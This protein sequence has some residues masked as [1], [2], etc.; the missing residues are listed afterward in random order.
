MNTGKVFVLGLDCATPQLLFERYSSELPNFRSLM[1]RGAYGRLRSSDPPITVPAWTCMFSSRDPGEIGL[2]GFRN[3]ADRSYDS[4]LIATSRQVKVK[5]AW[6]YVSDAGLDVVVLGVPQTFPPSPVRGVMVAS[7]LTPSKDSNFTYPPL[8]KWELDRLA[9]DDGGY[10]IDID[11]FRTD[12]KEALREAIFTMT[13]RRFNVIRAWVDQRPWN[14]FCAVEMG[15]DRLHHGF[16]RFADPEHRL[17]QAGNPYASL[18]VVSDHGARRMEGGVCVNEWLIE[19]GLL[20]VKSYPD[21][22]TPLRPDNVVW[23]ET[24]VWG[25]GGYYGRVFLNVE[26]REPQG[27]I[28]QPEVAGFREELT[29]ELLAL[30][31][32]EGKPMGTVVHTPEGLYRSVRGVPPDLLV[33]FGDLA[34]RSVG[35]LGHR[36]IHTFSND[37]GPDDANH[38]HHGVFIA[39]DAKLAGRGELEGVTLYDVLPTI[40]DRLDLEISEKLVGRVL[41]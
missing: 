41:G 35:S 11:N 23:N 37:T 7:F 26:G 8:V 34:W 32:P 31:D 20:K 10:V 40:L 6:D 16:W 5:R 3:R 24:R 9:G 15:P 28:P 18:L 14:L 2:Y 25:E 19:K 13:R 27:V 33:Y 22:I 12:D 39:R 38:D 30:G 1:E 4:L 29:Q 36:A 17:Y 21:K